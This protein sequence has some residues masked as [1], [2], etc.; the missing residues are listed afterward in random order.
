MQHSVVL[1]NVIN[2]KLLSNPL[3]FRFRGQEAVATLLVEIGKLNGEIFSRQYKMQNRT[4][5]CLFLIEQCGTGAI[6]VQ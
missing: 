5:C 4:N 1:S 3:L 6:L 2:S